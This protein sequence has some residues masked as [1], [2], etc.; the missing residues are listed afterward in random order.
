[1][2]SGG[3]LVC[4]YPSSMVGLSVEASLVT[5]RVSFDP[6]LHPIPS[7]SFISPPPFTEWKTPD[8]MPTVTF[9]SGLLAGVLA[10]AVTQPAD[11]IKTHMQIYP[12]KHTRVIATVRYVIQKSGTSGLFRGML[13]RCLRRTLMAALAW[14]VYEQV[15]VKFGL[16]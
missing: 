1:M 5:R 3:K 15:I 12:D 14:T 8:M 10:S 16:K 11:V 4:C 6:L 9:A 2:N 13:P 7:P